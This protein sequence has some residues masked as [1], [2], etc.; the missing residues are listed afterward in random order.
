MI[1]GGPAI[2]QHAGPLQAIELEARHLPT[3]GKAGRMMEHDADRRGMV[4]KAPGKAIQHVVVGDRQ[5]LVH[6][7]IEAREQK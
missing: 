2:A 6:R 4:L 3:G 5:Q 7:L 1:C